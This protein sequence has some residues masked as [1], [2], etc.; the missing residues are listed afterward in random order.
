MT[1]LTNKKD[2]AQQK[3]VSVSSAHLESSDF[4]KANALDLFNLP[5]N[6]I[7]TE[8]YVNVISSQAGTGV[9]VNVGFD[10]R[11]GADSLATVSLNTAA[12]THA[13]VNK[14]TQTGKLFTL[15]P[16]VAITSAEVEVVVVY[17]EYRVKSGSL[18]N[19]SES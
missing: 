13:S 17:I 12:L 8:V 4:D 14:P 19:Y 1:N 5:A 10:S 9:N 7:V 11:A 2:F 3:I 6:A 16:S 15:K 18:T